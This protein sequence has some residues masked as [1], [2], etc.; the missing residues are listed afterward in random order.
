MKTL[1]WIL[2]IVGMTAGIFLSLQTIKIFPLLGIP[3]LFM[4][5]CT[6]FVIVKSKGTPSKK[7]MKYLNVGLICLYIICMF[8]CIFFI[9]SSLIGVLIKSTT[10]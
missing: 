6:L 4:L 10:T 3:M 8:V 9:I 7:E 2:I 5:V 1:E